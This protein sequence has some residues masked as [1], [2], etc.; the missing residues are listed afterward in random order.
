MPSFKDSLT[1][2]SSY[3][4][5]SE[6]RS[7]QDTV[8]KALL[9]GNDALVLFPTGGGKSLCYQVPALTLP[10]LTIVI[11]PL[12]ALMQDQ[13][14]QLNDIGIRATFIN[15][16]ISQ[17][18]IE[19][20][21]I[22]ARNDLYKLIYCAPERL[23]TPIFQ[24]MLGDLSISLIAIDEAHC[25]SEWGHKFR[26]SYRKI[27][28]SLNTIW[29]STP[30]VALT[31]TATPKVQE[32][33]VLNLGLKDP[34]IVKKGYIRDN[35][36]YSVIK[37]E[38]K[39]RYL[40]KLL[41]RT[42]KGSSLLV[43]G[44][45]RRECEETADFISKLG[46]SCEAYH[47]GFESRKRAEIQKR[48]ISSKTQCVV[49]TNAFGMGIDKPD[50]RY[51]FHLHPPASLEAYYQEAG[52]AG[53]DGNSSW[54][55]LLWSDSDFRGLKE[56]IIN[57]NPNWDMLNDVY[58]TLND[59]L[60]LALGS[61]QET[62][63]QIDI[64]RL[65]SRNKLS[66]TQNVKVLEA[67]S[68]FGII[69]LYYPFKAEVGLVFRMSRAG[70]IDYLERISNDKKKEFVDRL[71]RIF[72]GHLSELYYLPMNMLLKELNV[73]RNSLVKALNVLLNEAVLN[74]EIREDKPIVFQSE[75]RM[76]QINISRKQAEFYRKQLLD[77]LSFVSKYVNTE[78]CRNSYFSAYFGDVKPSY[79]CGSCDNCNRPGPD[80]IL[81]VRR[82]LFDLLKNQKLSHEQIISTLKF[83]EELIE[84]GL[85]YL[86]KHG[87]LKMDVQEEITL[88]SV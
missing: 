79:S 2:L 70:F 7:G 57:S 8:V 78:L 59:E 74:Y 31:A 15:S 76:K 52:R 34:V 44:A 13:V 85:H 50:C 24:N 32:D 4:G 23:S 43:Y 88:Y 58:H 28:E 65:C 69:E 39:L 16:T 9:E 47:A 72:Y 82:E 25:I 45:T 86:R 11:S 20:R 5:F 18:D 56:N 62:K 61:Y 63:I 53:R 33:I 22:N 77:K 54:P 12:V 38:N 71:Y 21:L 17:R 46:I 19:Q 14:Q 1:I 29:D 51:V 83:D 73:T 87:L 67:L 36:H 49:S 37:T 55:V 27:K 41:Q 26:P 6:F 42:Q 68:D 3:W 35:L 64:D 40:K 60:N 10:N 48:W 80:D 81:R 30:V 66:R 84:S 75:P